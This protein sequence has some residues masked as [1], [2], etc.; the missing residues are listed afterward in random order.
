MGN[1][2]LHA[3]KSVS[4][5]GKIRAVADALHRVRCVGLA[6][7]EVCGDGRSHVPSGGKSPDADLLRIDPKVRSL[8]PYVA[9]RALTIEDW[10]RIVVAWPKAVVQYKGSH[11][12]LIEP[13]RS[14]RALTV[15]RQMVVP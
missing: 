1:L 6:A 15:Q 13:L 14:L 5:N 10:R 7:V 3:E 12:A 4:Q 9:H 11:A 2:L 8:R